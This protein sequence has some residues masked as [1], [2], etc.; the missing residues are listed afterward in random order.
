MFQHLFPSQ[1]HYGKLLNLWDG[2]L[3][4]RSGSL[5]ASLES[6]NY[7]QFWPDSLVPGPQS[8]GTLPHDP[9]VMSPWSQWSETVSQTKLLLFKVLHLTF[10]DLVPQTLRI[11]PQ[12]DGSMH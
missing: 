3:T 10:S 12:R 4:D 6:D 7:F 8:R 9:M 5:G 1:W 2:G 11:I